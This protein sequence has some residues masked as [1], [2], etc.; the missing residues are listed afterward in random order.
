[1][2]FCAGSVLQFHGERPPLRLSRTWSSWLCHLRVRNEN[3]SCL[4]RGNFIVTKTRVVCKMWKTQS[5]LRSILSSA[6]ACLK[7]IVTVRDV[8]PRLVEEADSLGIKVVNCYHLFLQVGCAFCHLIISVQKDKVIDI[9]MTS[10][11]PL[12]FSSP[13][14]LQYH[15]FFAGLQLLGRP[16]WESRRVWCSPT[17]TSS[18]PPLHALTSWDST[19]LTARSV[20]TQLLVDVSK[21]WSTSGRTS[22]SPSSLIICWSWPIFPS[23]KPLL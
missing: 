14:Q 16:Y 20:E 8:K 17:S 15:N 12:P 6:P 3:H 18:P 21:L 22:C 9:G 4:W 10:A 13:G 2:F 1:M 23:E 7:V 11:L 19:R 5:N